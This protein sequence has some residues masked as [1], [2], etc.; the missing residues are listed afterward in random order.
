MHE[1]V[2]LLRPDVRGPE[3]RR[4]SSALPPDL[5]GQ[6]AARLRVLAL[7]YA[8]AVFLAGI[9]PIQPVPIP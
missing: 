6:S 7:L 2:T 3:A 5:L 4:I 1:Q 8:L 9:F